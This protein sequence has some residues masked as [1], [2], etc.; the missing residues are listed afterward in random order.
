MH[1]EQAFQD[2]HETFREPYKV[3]STVG[4]TATAK[5]GQGEI[6]DFRYRIEIIRRLGEV[7]YEAQFW[8][9]PVTGDFDFIW[10]LTSLRTKHPELSRDTPEAAL[11]AALAHLRQDIKKQLAP[12]S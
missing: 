6:T 8:A 12:T 5:N 2:H 10:V 3:L 11:K 1:L 9:A 7:S 4:F